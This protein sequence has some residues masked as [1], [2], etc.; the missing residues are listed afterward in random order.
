VSLSDVDACSLRTDDI[1]CCELV[2][3]V[4]SPTCLA[5]EVSYP[6]EGISMVGNRK[7]QALHRSF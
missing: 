7:L 5:S 1:A 2:V 6:Y 3:S 4:K